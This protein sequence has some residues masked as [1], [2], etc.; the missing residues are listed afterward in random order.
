M[1]VGTVYRD[2]ALV[3]LVLL[4]GAM[5][6]TTSIDEFVKNTYVHGVPYDQATQFPASVTPQLVAML[7]DGTKQAFWP[8]IVVTLGIVGDNRAT[9]P[10][11]SFFEAGDGILP[12]EVFRAKTSV[13][14]SLGYVINHTHS[15][16]ALKYL[17]RG[18]HPSSWAGKVKWRAAFQGDD[19]T[20]NE[21]LSR[22]AINGLAL[23]GN[24]SALAT[25]KGFVAVQAAG[26]ETA[27]WQS[28]RSQLEEAIRANDFIAKNGLT[29][30]YKKFEWQ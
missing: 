23:S 24:S 2:A 22:L 27:F 30:Y 16:Q 29:A 4:Q 7:K 13:L 21:H 11:I 3:V 6:Q 19:Q 20:R 10:L 26:E 28:V 1:S 5:A 9:G 18:V 17:Q 8:N 12:E 14:M 15:T 25:L